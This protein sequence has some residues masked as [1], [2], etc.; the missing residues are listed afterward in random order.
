MSRIT[1]SL[2]RISGIELD[3]ACNS[4]NESLTE[5]FDSYMYDV[6]VVI[7]QWQDVKKYIAEDNYGE[8]MK[9]LQDLQYGCGLLAEDLMSEIDKL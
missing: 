9:I 6:D 3:E 4:E 7:N 1:E 2:Y 8:A 5:G